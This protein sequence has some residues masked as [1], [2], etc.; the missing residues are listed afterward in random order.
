MSGLW[1]LIGWAMIMLHFGAYA[2]LP[3]PA[4]WGNLAGLIGTAALA[5]AGMLFSWACVPYRNQRSS[6][7]IIVSI[8]GSSTLY[9]GLQAY[10]PTANWALALAAV[11]IGI[12]PL[13]IAV[14]DLRQFN[15]F[16]RWTLVTLYGC[17]SHF[18]AGFR[19]G[20]MAGGTGG[21]LTLLF[22]DLS[23]STFVISGTPT[24]ARQL[25]PPSPLQDSSH[26]WVMSILSGRP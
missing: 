26:G 8:I 6:K 7:A 13:T 2:I 23:A 14:F 1:L 3:A 18:L 16:L 21:E 19:C 12:L 20:Q 5:W 10:A 9:L 15:H 4:P 25:G 22:R 24:P 11:L 17:L